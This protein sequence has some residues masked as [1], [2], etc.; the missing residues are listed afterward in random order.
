MSKINDLF[1][2]AEPTRNYIRA[3]GAAFLALVCWHMQE[4]TDAPALLPA[5]GAAVF[6]LSAITEICR[7]L[8]RVDASKNSNE[9]SNR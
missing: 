8:S 5:L 2:P 7:A 9:S 1:Y 6:G 4:L 3:A